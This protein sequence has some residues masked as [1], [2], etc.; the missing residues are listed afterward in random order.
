MSLSQRFVTTLIVDAT[1]QLT[2]VQA[3]WHA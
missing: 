1:C 3:R 2:G